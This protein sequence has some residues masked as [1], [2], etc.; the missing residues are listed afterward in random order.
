MNRRKQQLINEI[1]DRVAGILL[2]EGM[3]TSRSILSH[4]KEDPDLNLTLMIKAIGNPPPRPSHYSEDDYRHE[5]W[6]S[7]KDVPSVINDFIANVDVTFLNTAED[8]Y[9]TEL[10]YQIGVIP[11]EA[12]VK[13]LSSIQRYMNNVEQ[14]L[15]YLSLLDNS[16]V[17]DITDT[18]METVADMIRKLYNSYAI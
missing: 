18:A 14:G 11:R 1:A 13:T 5:H 17:L 16:T 8:V 4:M 12:R 3:V 7:F 15:E 9:L 6:R 2:Q 10:E